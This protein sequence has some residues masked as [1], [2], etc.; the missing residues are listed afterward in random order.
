MVARMEKFAD[1]F[2]PRVSHIPL[3]YS[4]FNEC[5]DAFHFKT[6]CTD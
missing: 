2:E 6:D 4:T 5:K 1:T 3:V